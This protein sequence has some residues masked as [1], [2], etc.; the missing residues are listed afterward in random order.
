MGSHF[1]YKELIAISLFKLD[2]E[3][4]VQK[5]VDAAKSIAARLITARSL[6]AGHNATARQLAR[7]NADDATLEDKSKNEIRA[8]QIRIDTL[9]ATFQLESDLTVS[10]N[11][12]LREAT[13]LEVE[14]IAE[15]FTIAAAD[16]VTSLAALAIQTELMAR[17]LP[18]AAGL[19]SFAVKAKAEL[20]GSIEMLTVLM[21]A[22]TDS[23]LAGDAKATLQQVQ[24]AASPRPSPPQ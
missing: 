12:K 1:K 16:V 17:F 3:K 9:G 23:V 14:N 2:V 5:I 13:T 21:R 11:K 18:D 6:R 7:Y 19:H 8:A 15:R 24:A 10:T 22:Y 4:H 20:P